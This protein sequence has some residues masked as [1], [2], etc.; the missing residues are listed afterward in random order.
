MK[1]EIYFVRHGQTEWNI[2]R[3]YQGCGDSPLTEQGVNQAKALSKHI[4]N[5]HFDAIYCSPRGRAQE[6][7]KIV[8]GNRDLEIITVDD[9][10]EINVGEYE[11]RLYDDMKNENPDLYHGFWESPD[12][13]LPKTGESFTDVGNRTY[14]ALLKI[15]KKHSGQ[16]VL[17]VSHAV[18]IMSAL[19]KIAGI[20]LHRFWEKMLHQTSLSIAE[21]ENGEFSIIKYGSTKHLE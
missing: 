2:E 11:G 19:N 9:F 6:T 1:T 15:A 3:R 12:L 17:I 8:R 16:R 4:E 13:F 10:Q 21:Y 5:V 18:A 20:P 7:A 14:P